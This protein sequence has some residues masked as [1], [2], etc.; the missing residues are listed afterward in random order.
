MT[1]TLCHEDFTEADATIRLLCDCRLH[2][3]CFFRQALQIQHFGDIR[4]NTCNTHIVPNELLNELEVVHGQEG[5]NLVIQQM[6]EL[7]EFRDDLKSL[8]KQSVLV[9]K[10]M[11]AADKKHKEIATDLKEE[12]EPYVTVLK[13]MVKAA[14]KKLVDSPENKELNRLRTSYQIRFG[15]FFRKWGVQNYSLRRALRGI[16]AAAPLIPV[17]HY[18]RR[19]EVKFNI[20]IK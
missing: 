4:C 13:V 18:R 6:W 3:L 7:P 11:T 9:G 19:G 5:G 1:C 2:T 14:K 17:Y 20:W 12:T 16:R 15:K 10:A 8:K